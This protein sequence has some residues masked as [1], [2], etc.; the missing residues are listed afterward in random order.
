MRGNCIRGAWL[1]AVL[2]ALVPASLARGQSPDDAPIELGWPWQGGRSLES[3]TVLSAAEPR[4]VVV[5][6]Q[7]GAQSAGYAPAHPQLPIPLGSTRPEDGGFY[8]AVQGAMYRQTLPLRNQPIAY[9]GFQTSDNSLGVPTGTFIGS[10]RPALN[11]NNLD[12]QV[13]YQPG[14]QIDLGWKF[15]DGSALTLSWFYLS[16]AQYRAAATLVPPLNSQRDDLADSFISAPVFNFPPEYSGPANKVTGGSATVAYGIWNAASIMTIKFEQRFQ[17]WELTYRYPIVDQEDYR[18]QALVG[19]RFAWIWER[20]KWRTTSYGEDNGSITA[21]PDDVGIYTNITSNRMYGVHTGCQTECYIG[22]GFAV[23]LEC[24]VAGFLDSVK[25]R[26]KYET[27]NKFMGRPESK[28]A[29]REFSVVPEFS[30]MLALQW[31]P[32]EFIEVRFG[33]QL[34]YFMN[35]FASTRP[36]D[37]NYSHVA[38]VWD[39]V[40]RLFDGFQGG[41]CIT[42]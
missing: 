23:M 19:P 5:R 42:F 26:A 10:L 7:S 18:V 21:G 25:Q 35:T 8:F 2:T 22:H 28:R 17:Q 27:A 29:K 20:F 15:R 16:T 32:T 11:V 24:Q 4:G 31:Y 33:Y 9:R 37:F 30:G 39:H 14:S 13:A 41:V 1:L 38:P 3:P 6:G 36:I 12:G 40:N 34:M